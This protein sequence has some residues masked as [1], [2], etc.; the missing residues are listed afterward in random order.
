MDLFLRFLLVFCRVS[1]ILMFIPL[2]GDRNVPVQAQLAISLAVSLILVGMVPPATIPSLKSAGLGW[3]IG[4]VLREVLVGVVIALVVVLLFAGVQMAGQIVGLQIGFGIVNVIDPQS[5]LQVPLLGQFNF[6][7]ALMLFLC[8]DGH[9]TLLQ[10]I[11]TSYDLIPVGHAQFTGRIAERFSVLSSGIFS[12]ALK[13]GAPVM[14]ILL[15]TNVALGVI[16]R[17]VPQM[18]IF[19]VG[20]P[21]QIVIGLLA[22]AFSFSLFSYVFLKEWGMFQRELANIMRFMAG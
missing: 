18:N 10:A 3:F 16:A 7:L 8:V 4:V 9:H 1:V 20:F 22:L 11:K 17:T 5:D 6:L 19:I 12:I 21:I 13:L 2:F 15:L 14:I